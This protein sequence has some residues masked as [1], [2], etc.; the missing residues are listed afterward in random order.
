[1]RI[2]LKM[3]GI[4]TLIALASFGCRQDNRTSQQGDITDN[5][6]P[7]VS[8]IIS[9]MAET[10]LECKTYRDTGIVTTNYKSQR[11]TEKDVKHFST[12]MVRPKQF[13]FEYTEERPPNSRYVIWRN[14]N[15]VRT[16]WDVTQKSDRLTHW[17]WHWLVQLGFR[18]ALPTLSRL[19]CCRATLE[20]AC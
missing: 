19:C 20:D 12:A 15:H 18:A 4:I 9:R 6:T 5:R 1:M 16:W 13:R 8:E 17:A 10:Y 2:Q 14:G 11:G 7:T 3:I